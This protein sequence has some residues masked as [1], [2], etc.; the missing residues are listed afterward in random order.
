R[1]AIQYS[2]Y[3]VSWSTGSAQIVFSTN[4]TPFRNESRRVTGLT[5]EATYYFRIWTADEVPNWSGI[6]NETSCYVPIVIPGVITDLTAIQGEYWGTIK[7][8][9]TAPGADGYSGDL[10]AGC[11]FAIQWS[12]ITYSNPNAIVWST[13]TPN[14]RISTGSPIAVK[15]GDKQDWIVDTEL[16]QNS[17][18]YYFRIWTADMKAH[19]SEKSTLATNVYLFCQFGLDLLVEPTYYDYGILLTNISSVSASAVV[20]TST[21]NVYQNYGLYID[22]DAFAALNTEWTV[23][24]TTTGLNEFLLEGIFNSARPDSSDFASGGGNDVI[25]PYSPPATPVYCNFAG[26]K[27]GIDSG[28]SSNGYNVGAASNRNLWFKLWTPIA[29]HTTSK[30]TIP[31]V[32]TAQ[33]T[34]YSP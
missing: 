3:S 32:I 34:D 8:T 23:A 22:T 10:T 26:T 11:T 17:T 5:E 7:L 21:G 12:T 9:W 33:P 2:S 19:W 18:Y 20:V 27:Y 28:G 6:S 30:Q 1:Y 25:I 24:T 16:P 4:T 29:T 13:M 15:P 31:V 14:I